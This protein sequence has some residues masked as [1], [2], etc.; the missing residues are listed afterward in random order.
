M[1]SA[2]SRALKPTYSE[3]PKA[4]RT[5]T[6]PAD[7]VQFCKS[8]RPTLENRAIL[9]PAHS[10]IH[11]T[12]SHFSPDNGGRVLELATF[13]SP[14]PQN[15][16][17]TSRMKRA[18]LLTTIVL[19]FSFSTA[20]QDTPK[21]ELFGGYSYTGSGSNGYDVSIAGNINNWFG[22]VAEVGGQFST[23]TDQGFTEKIRTHSFLFGPKFSY[24][25]HRAVPFAQALF[26]VA[27]VKTET[28]EFGPLVS[29]SDTG[30]ALAVGGGLDVTLNR[31]VA[32]RVV[33]IDYLRTNFFG[34]T[35]NKGRI[36]AGV[37]LR[38]GKK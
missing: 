17:E 2:A 15:M 6:S 8:G 24:R 27:K 14:A 25:R 4:Y 34:G 20:G 5:L 31:H 19:V 9:G 33:Q 22:V 3:L 38:F 13:F 28:D 30:F 11:R 26:G 23:F 7:H 12:S 35:Q 32:V 18:F 1:L 16:K 36:A 37:V 29:F 10:L 21:A